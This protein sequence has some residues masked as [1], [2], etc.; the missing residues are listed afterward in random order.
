MERHLIILALTAI[1]GGLSSVGFW[2]FVTWL[3]ARGDKREE[4]ESD[5]LR[6]EAR[7]SRDAHLDCEQRLDAVEARLQAVEHHHASYL[8]RW[9]KGADKRLIWINDRAFLAIFAP[10]GLAR[11]EVMGR[12]FEELL[13]PLAAAEIDRLDQMAL[14]H[15]ELPAANVIQLHPMLPV[16]VVVKVVA[17]GREGELVFEGYAY[18]TNDKTLADAIGVG[19]QRQAIEAS[20]EHLLDDD[21]H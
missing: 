8:P 17:V 4:K 20:A 9:I 2:K 19:R 3:L 14:A 13:D 10:L 15:P 1:G 6:R 12:T 5:R 11:E 18:R 21:R 16:M 7:E